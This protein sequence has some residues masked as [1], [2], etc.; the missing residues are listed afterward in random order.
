MLFCCQ[1]GLRIWD[2]GLATLRYF[3]DR[4]S[5]SA[6]WATKLRVLELVIRMGLSPLLSLDTNM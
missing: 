1:V 2:C 6:G 5:V 3:W 4:E